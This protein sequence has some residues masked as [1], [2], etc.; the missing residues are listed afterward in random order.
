MRTL[1]RSADRR[2]RPA[3]APFSFDARSGRSGCRCSA[4]R[5]LVR[6]CRR[7]RSRDPARLHCDPQPAASPSLHVA[8]VAA[9]GVLAH[10]A[11]QH[12]QGIR[13]LICGGEALPAETRVRRRS[14]LPGARTDQSLRPDRDD[15]LTRP[16]WALSATTRATAVPIGRPIWNTRVYVWTGLAACACWGRGRALHRGSGA[17]ARLSGPGGADGGAVRGGPVRRCGEPDVPHRRP[18]ALAADGVLEFLGR[19]DAQVKLRGFRI[20]P[21]EIEAALV[22]HAAVCAGGGDRARGSARQPSGW[23]PMWW[24]RPVRRPMRR[25]CGRMWRRS[26]PDYMVPAAFVVLER[27]P[28]TPNGKLDRRALPAPDVTRREC[29]AAPRTPQEEV[30]C[31]LFAEVLGLERV[32]ID[33]NFFELGGHSL[34]ATRLI[35]RIRADAG[36]RARDPQPVRGADRRGA[37]AASG[38]RRRR[39]G[40][41][42]VLWRGRPRSRCRLRSGGCGSSTGWKGRSATYTIPLAVRLTGELESRRWRPRSATW[43]R[44][45][46]ACA[47]SSPTR[48]GAAA[49][50]PGASAA[51]PRLAVETV[52]EAALPRRWRRGASGLRSAGEPPL[53]AHLF[54]L[55]RD[56]HVLL[57][58]LHHIAGDGWSLAPLARDLARA[59][60]G[61][62]RGACAPICRRCRCNMPTTRCGSTRCWATRAIRRA[63]SRA[64]WRT[65]PRRSKDLPEQIDLPSDRPRPAVS[66]YRGEQRAARA[67]GRAARRSCWRWRAT[68]GASLFMVLQA[69]PCGAADAAGG[70]HRHPDRQPDRG[71]HRQR[72][73]RSGRVL[74][75]HAGAAHRHVRQSELPGA[76]RRGC[77]RAIWRPTATRTCRSSGWWRCSTRRARCRA[78]RCSR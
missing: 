52:T 33:D 73:R 72:A 41:R 18:G 76:G 35:G 24:R 29:G 19:A 12:Y 58:L 9:A 27:L 4:A 57:L 40:R 16:D 68:S 1:I 26:L 66:S 30:L 48:W 3:V 34:L 39:R 67:R 20:E 44:G 23:W 7:M 53:R 43:W 10:E 69:G 51:R 25:R 61:A 28:L 64:S 8:A 32:G 59:L 70:G 15:D 71:A 49:A 54:V 2:R 75:Q 31:A 17:G 38:R 47:R 22:R 74:R 63:R 45:T 21:G 13:R 78:I 46:R 6:R 50:D 55:R 62:P 5:A 56:E 77:G 36:C 11:S 42:C 60:R 14:V 65:G 37:G